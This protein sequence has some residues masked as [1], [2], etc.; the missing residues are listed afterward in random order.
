[1]E[2]QLC[3]R[4][5]KSLADHI[6]LIHSVDPRLTAVR[7]LTRCGPVLIL[8][9]YM[10]T[11]YHNEDSLE[12]YCETCGRIDALIMK[13]DVAEVI[14]AGDFSCGFGIHVFMLPLQI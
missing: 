14:V 12:Q 7:L 10:P 9:V 2:E 1:M 8:N 4:Y 13:Q 11:D 5:R 6:T 3:C